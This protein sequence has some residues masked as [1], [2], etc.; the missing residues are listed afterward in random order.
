M[1]NKYLSLV[2]QRTR[3]SLWNDG[4]YVIVEKKS[5]GKQNAHSI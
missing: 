5:T 2:Q 3:Q 1:F 4:T